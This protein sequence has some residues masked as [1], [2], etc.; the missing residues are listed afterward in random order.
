MDSLLQESSFQILVGFLE[1]L[2]A[3]EFCRIIDLI[4]PAVQLQKKFCFRINS[5]I[6]QGAAYQ[7]LDCG[8]VDNGVAHRSG[9]D[10]L[11]LRKNGI[12]VSKCELPL[13][14]QE[15]GPAFREVTS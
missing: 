6:L 11:N 1:R 15:G 13:L 3:G 5:G 4:A 14:Q 2:Q 9:R 12:A 10:I 8:A 7:L